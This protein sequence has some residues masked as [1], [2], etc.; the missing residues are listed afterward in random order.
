MD[1]RSQFGSLRR[2]FLGSLY[3]RC[4][5]LGDGGPIVSFSF[6]DFPRSAYTVGGAIL[7]DFG[8]RGTYY[9]AIGL[10]NSS[11][12]LGE[13]FRQGDLEA[14]VADGHE[15]ASHTFS[16]VS[17]RSVSN[18]EF[19]KEVDKGRRAIQ[20]ITGK[21]D[22]G[23]F[24]FPFGDFTL[25]ARRS[26]SARVSSCRSI[27]GGLNRTDIDLSLLRANSIYGDTDKADLA[28]QLIAENERQKGWLIFYSH[29]VH[30]SPSRYGCTPK[31]LESVVACVSRSRSRIMT[32][33]DV[34][35]EI[36]AT[37]RQSNFADSVSA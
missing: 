14:L 33:E 11:N 4:V 15:L 35:I 37:D 12:G 29:D 1:C 19:L 9:T 22:S 26:L 13:Q 25:A 7:K 10:M 30:L 32:V 31:L 8:A 20:E 34:L 36:S 3:S 17:C 16:H 5:P 28:K 2:H 18:I 23:N 24:A 27:W 6:D 21:E